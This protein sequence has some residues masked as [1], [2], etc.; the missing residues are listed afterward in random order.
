MM[1]K[2]DKVK[3]K[4]CFFFATP[5]HHTQP[6]DLHY[7]FR[8]PASDHE[9]HPKCS[10]TSGRNTTITATTDLNHLEQRYPSRFLIYPDV[11]RTS[12]LNFR[13]P[14]AERDHERGGAD[15]HRERPG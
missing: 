4:D 3:F 1:P 5:L 12:K 13:H 8:W 15:A 14:L 10:A 6:L 7:P 9:E 2:R 11:K